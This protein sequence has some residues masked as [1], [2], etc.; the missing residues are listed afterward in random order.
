MPAMMSSTPVPPIWIRSAARDAVAR[1][2]TGEY[3]RFLDVIGVALPRG[4]AGGLL[5]GVV[6]DPAHLLR[7]Q[8]GDAPGGRRGAEI[9][10]DAV[11]AVMGRH[12]VVQTRRASW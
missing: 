9:A 5:R 2:Q 3:Q 8:T 6:Q 1:G 4:D 10:G 12:L 11:R 7:I